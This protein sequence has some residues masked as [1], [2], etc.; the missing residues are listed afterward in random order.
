[1]LSILLRSEA[2]ADS[3]RWFAFAFAEREPFLTARAVAPRRSVGLT[4]RQTNLLSLP[5]PPMVR[6][7]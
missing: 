7:L 1:M 5:R 2:V 6:V 3:Q 4:V